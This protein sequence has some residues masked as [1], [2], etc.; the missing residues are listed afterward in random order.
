MLRARLE[1]QGLQAQLVL[2]ALRALLVPLEPLVLQVLQVL[3]VLLGLQVQR[4][5]QV[6]WLQVRQE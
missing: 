5:P 6:R 1:P 4:G 2:R 3:Q